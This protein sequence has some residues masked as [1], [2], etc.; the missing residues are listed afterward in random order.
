MKKIQLIIV[1]LLCF[2]AVWGQTAASADALFQAGDYATAQ[3]QYA[4]LIQSYPNHALYLY[5]YA[6]CAQEQGDYPTAKHYFELAGNRYDLKHFHLGEVC[7]KLWQPEV[8][9]AS[10]ETYLTRPNIDPTRATYVQQQIRYAE[11]LQRYMRRVEKIQVI[12]SIDVPI[13][14]MLE[15]CVLSAEAGQLAYDSIEQ[16]VY[17]NQRGDRMLWG[18]SKDSAQYIVS[19]HRLLDHWTEPDTL[20]T[21]INRFATQTNPYVLS[22]GVTLY[23]AACDSNG[24]G[25]YDLYVTRYNTAT[26]TYT[27][28][29]NLGLPYNSPANDYL[30]VIDEGRNV[31]YLATDRFSGKDSVRIYSFVPAEYKQYWRNISADSLVAYAQLRSY[32]LATEAISQT[33]LADTTLSVEAAD[34]DTIFFV[35]ND[36]TIYTSLDDFKNAI[37]RKKYQEWEG[38]QDV[39]RKEQQQLEDLRYQY[40]NADDTERKKLT[41]IILRL[42]N[43]QSQLLERYQNLLLEIRAT[44]INH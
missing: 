23:Y 7:M 20:P 19:T 3:K 40:S 4:R 31:G 25:G 38:V 18:G 6:R 33:E 34:W 16:V 28:P 32:M 42:E 30:L 26:E 9:I 12:D 39:I 17:T 8:A 11:K 10:Y 36:S 1:F 22:D 21:S 13:N 2:T 27:T 41:P 14:K 29:E 5:R 35:L 24:L 44:E 15:A 37:A 43:N